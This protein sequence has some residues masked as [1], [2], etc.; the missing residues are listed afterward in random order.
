MIQA[1]GL[2]PGKSAYDYPV[3]LPGQEPTE[4]QQAQMNLAQIA[5]VIMAVAAAKSGLES[6]VTN[7]LVAVLRT[8]DLTTEV[9]VS[10]FVE[11]VK[12]I[13][14][15]ATQK[16][17]EVTWAGFSNRAAIVGIEFP[18]IMPTE[19]EIPRELY[20]A[21]STSTENAYRRVAEEYKE[22]LRRT[23]DDPII[24]ELVRQLET[25]ALT[26]LPRPDNLSDDA[27]QR[28]ADNEETWVQAFRRA[29]EEARKIQ[30]REDAEAKISRSVRENLETDPSDGEW[31]RADV[32]AFAGDDTADALATEAARAAERE[33]E[34]RASEPEGQPKT[35][36]EDR[37][38]PPDDEVHDDGEGEQEDDRLIRL[39]DAE[40]DEVIE[41]Y[42]EQ[43]AEERVER[44]VSQDIQGT[45]RNTHQLA[46]RHTDPSQ[47]KGF[48]RVIHP[49]LSESGKSCGLCIVASTMMYTRGD[50]LPI[51]SGC[52]CETAEVYVVDGKEYD[53]GNQINL[54]DLGTFYREAGDSTH[55]WDLKRQRY[56]VYNHPEYGPT[57]VNATSKKARKTATEVEYN[58]RR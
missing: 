52:N 51:H 45:S 46:M 25:Q 18:D 44:M 4:E 49:E 16:A 32:E 58:S 24:S 5:G 22:N 11:A 39:T 13:L 14:P 8:A 1:Q 48:R 41:R 33:E 6:A 28:V 7:Q 9:G 50:L 42:A 15:M 12:L 47:V 3:L 26:P 55:G 54:Q 40:I 19:E 27:I 34:R 17:R 43:K 30:G 56:E 2:P 38:T 23:K 36:D 20:H 31:H 21:R 10:A 37:V 35:S 57:L 29:E 53:P